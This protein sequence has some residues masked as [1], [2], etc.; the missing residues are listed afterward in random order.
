MGWD[1][2]QIAKHSRI[3]D[4]KS[5]AHL[6]SP[7]LPAGL[8]HQV[9]KD[10]AVHLR[11]IRASVKSRKK[12]RALVSFVPRQSH[13]DRFN[14]TSSKD[15]FRGFYTLF[16]I[17]LLL[18]MLNTFYTSFEKSGQ[19][20]SL[21]FATLFSKDARVLALSDAVLVGSLFACVPFAKVLKRGW[22]RYW[23]TAVVFQHLYQTVLLF[24]V[25]RWTRYRYVR[26]ATLERRILTDEPLSFFWGFSEWP[27]VQS[28]FFVLH[29]LAM[30]M[31]IHSYM[32]TN[33]NM[34]DAYHKMRRIEGM[35]EE[36]VAEIEGPGE[37]GWSRAL[38]K[39][40]EE[41]LPAQRETAL[42]AKEEVEAFKGQNGNSKAG[43]N[44][45]EAQRGTSELRHRANANVVT[46]SADA[47]EYGAEHKQEPAKKGE[48]QQK[49]AARAEKDAKG[50]AEEKENENSEN[51]GT[52][53]TPSPIRD[54]HPLATH[55][56]SMIST[57][58]REIETLREDLL[59]PGHDGDTSKRVMW[60][61]NVTYWNFFDYL[62]VPTLV[63]ELEY[64]R[65]KS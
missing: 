17:G 9:D 15:P 48:A 37:A 29:T 39:A 60:P 18:L 8:T 53:A 65:T 22:V 42:A 35:L 47:H 24:A 16:W 36:R 5:C 4:G 50:Q 34:A 11:P 38:D 33:G 57:L 51:K 26:R 63:Y 10:G 40:R 45:L 62:L 2:A 27:W 58:A 49:E 31:K 56:E 7:Y 28:G 32:A 41:D 44:S 52:A 21:T 46:R 1:R 61:E 19:I 12:V 43:W 6:V 20:V 25:I 59:S 14:I 30:M 23:P 54:P 64:P 3:P 13:F 55:P